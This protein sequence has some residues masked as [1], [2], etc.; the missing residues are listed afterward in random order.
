VN[1]LA[2]TLF[3]RPE[4]WPSWGGIGFFQSC[5]FAGVFWAVWWSAARASK[6]LQ[7]ELQA[8]EGAAHPLPVDAHRG[9]AL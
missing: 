2:Q 1:F 7:V 3:F 4:G 9:D 8:T 5:L 6:H